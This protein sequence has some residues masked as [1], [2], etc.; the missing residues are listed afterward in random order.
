MLICFQYRKHYVGMRFPIIIAVRMW[1]KKYVTLV[2][3]HK[4]SCS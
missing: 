3:D 2:N 1:K 4:V